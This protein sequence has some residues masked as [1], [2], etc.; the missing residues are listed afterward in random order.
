MQGKNSQCMVHVVNILARILTTC[1]DNKRGNATWIHA[2]QTV[3]CREN[4]IKNT[5]TIAIQISQTWGNT[6]LYMYARFI[7]CLR[8]TSVH[9]STPQFNY[10]HPFGP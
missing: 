7:R 5:S 6:V 2:K 9:T 8:Q 4:L 1:I 3:G 10:S